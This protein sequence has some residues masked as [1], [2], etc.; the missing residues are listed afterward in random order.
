MSAKLMSS[1]HNYILYVV[2][3]AGVVWLLVWVR[4]KN[5]IVV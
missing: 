4:E 3:G 2:A 5:L 1:L